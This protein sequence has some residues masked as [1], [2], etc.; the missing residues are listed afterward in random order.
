MKD[1]PVIV[2][3]FNQRRLKFEKPLQVWQTCRTEQVKSIFEKVQEAIDG[4]YY[5]VGY[6]NYECAPAFDTK[7]SVCPSDEEVPLVWFGIYD[8][9]TEEEAAREHGDYSVSDWK[10]D[11][12]REI[13]E[14]NIE[15]IHAAIAR[16][17]TYQVN[18][19]TRLR[20]E[21]S[22]DDFAYYERLKEAQQADYSAYLNMGDTGYCPFRPS[23]SFTGTEMSSVRSR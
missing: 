21:F 22:G 11:I 18:Y 15:S 19:S 9:P 7:L 16:G 4:Q 13:Y 20:A 12:D 6:V 8:K 17:E 14:D 23:F 3:D 5:V 10:A 1:E 2:I